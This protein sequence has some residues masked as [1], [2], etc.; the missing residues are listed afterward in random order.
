[1][2]DKEIRLAEETCDLQLKNIVNADALY[3]RLESHRKVKHDGIKLPWNKADGRIMLRPKE[4]VLMG[5]Y[6]GH[7]KS[8]I[9]A[10]IA[11][12]AVEQGNHVGIAS[13]ELPA[14]EIMEQFGEF[15]ANR[16]MPPMPYMEKVKT[17]V[18]PYLHIYDV[19]DVISPE[20]ALQMVI[21]L[22]AE[23]KCKLII[24]DAL[25]M[26]NASND[27]NEEQKFS[28]RLAAI[29][30]RYDTCIL[31]VHHVRKPDGVNGE[32]KIPGKYEFIGTSHLANISSTI[33]T[34]WHD[35]EK[36]YQRNTGNT[37]DDS[38]DDSKPDLILFICKQRNNKF[39]GK[40]GLWQSNRSRVFCETHHRNYTPRIYQ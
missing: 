19:V 36:A 35:K 2:K 7:F 21:A 14:E 5:G 25:M 39:E 12:N 23:K 31:L 8:T 18:N 40:L 20:I 10:Q 24:L 9:A 30:K 17:S 22:V 1:M 11:F 34:I 27:L 28:Q 3:Q 4:L 38:F 32:K 33:I 29:A 6:S 16:E 26:M 37:D 15:A 13:L